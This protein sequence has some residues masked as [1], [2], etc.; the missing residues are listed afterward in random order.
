MFK[1]LNCLGTAENLKTSSQRLE[2]DLKS[3][4]PLTTR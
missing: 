4:T 3:K 2:Q 1:E